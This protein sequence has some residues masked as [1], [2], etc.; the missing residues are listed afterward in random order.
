LLVPLV[1]GLL[2]VVAFGE[3]FDIPKLVGGA[4]V[5]VGLLALQRGRTQVGDAPREAA[6]R[7]ASLVTRA[8]S[9]G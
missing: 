3:E 1:S 2:S 4:L 7:D 6:P 5:T 9:R 8:I